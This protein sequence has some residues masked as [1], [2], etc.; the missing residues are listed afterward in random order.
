M[1]TAD[2]LKQL[3][4][5]A[6]LSAR[7]LD[8]LLDSSEGYTSLLES[9]ERHLGAEFANKYAQALGCSLDWLIGG[10][11]RAPTRSEVLSAVKA[12]KAA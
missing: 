6:G 7:A 9:G 4:G 2:R 5:L 1:S 12:G 10:R 11:G 3:R 8:R